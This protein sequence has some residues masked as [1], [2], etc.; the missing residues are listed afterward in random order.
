MSVLE[1]PEVYVSLYEYTGVYGSVLEWMGVYGSVR[2]CMVVVWS[3]WT[4]TR[5]YVCVCVYGIIREFTIILGYTNSV[6]HRVFLF[7]IAIKA[8]ELNRQPW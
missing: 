6:K 4:C 5:V 3:V 7:N 8:A 2:A 1:C